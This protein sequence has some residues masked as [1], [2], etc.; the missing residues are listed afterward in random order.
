[1]NKVMVDTS[2]WI[3]YF[4]NN[5]DIVNIV[6]DLLD[7]NQLYITGPV[8]AE[9]IQGIRTDK[10]LELLTR[11]IDAIPYQ[12]CTIE[13]WKNAG[14]LSYKLRKEGKVIPLTDMLIAA[15]SIRFGMKVF[16]YDRHFDY[17]PDVELFLMQK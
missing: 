12:S 17:I 6:D 16:T 15:V 11:Y 7:K 10:D 13:D 4:R 8:I 5:A 1:M 14:M 3:E 2:I 9:L